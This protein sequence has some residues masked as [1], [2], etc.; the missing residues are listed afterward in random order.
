MDHRVYLRV[1]G[2]AQ[3]VVIGEMEN[4]DPQTIT[5]LLEEVGRHL[6]GG[7]TDTSSLY[8]SPMFKKLNEKLQNIERLTG[9]SFTLTIDQDTIDMPGGLYLHLIEDKY[10]DPILEHRATMSGMWHYLDGMEAMLLWSYQLAT[11]EESNDTSCV[12]RG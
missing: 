7:M 3:E 8:E 10:H 4:P 2:I 6:W 9:F 5:D 12:S 1:E 11:E